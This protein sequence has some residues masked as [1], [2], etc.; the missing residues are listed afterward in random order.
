[1]STTPS[2]LQKTDAS[3][4][5]LLIIRLFL[6][7][8]LFF[9]LHVTRLRIAIAPIDGILTNSTKEWQDQNPRQALDTIVVAKLGESNCHPSV[10]V[11]GCSR[12]VSNRKSHHDD[13]FRH[14][15]ARRNRVRNNYWPLLPKSSWTLPK[16]RRR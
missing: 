1:M 6:G 8:M 5:P 15:H 16:R 2:L 3:G 13:Y 11:A 10:T 9:V 4:L 14:S 12:Y 7:G